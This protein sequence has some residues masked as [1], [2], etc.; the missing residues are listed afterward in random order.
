M[1]FLQ[2][3]AC[4][5]AFWATVNYIIERTLSHIEKKRRRNF[6]GKVDRYRR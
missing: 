4:G 6:E 5:I 2:A 3:F 1:N